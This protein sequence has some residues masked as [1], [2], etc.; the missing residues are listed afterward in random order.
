MFEQRL[1]VQ[2]C[3]VWRFN[4]GIFLGG[5]KTPDRSATGCLSNSVSGKGAHSLKMCGGSNV[6]KG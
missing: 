5:V 4:R 3:H 1:P 6:S 2:I